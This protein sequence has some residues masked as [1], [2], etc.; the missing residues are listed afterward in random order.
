MHHSLGL[1]RLYSRYREWIL[2]YYIF[3]AGWTKIPLV[4]GLV[5]WV[6]NLYG[7]K[8][9][10][11]CLLTLDEA[12]EIIDSSAALALGPCTCRAVFKNCDHPLEAEIMVGLGHN[13]FIEE[14]PHDYRKINRQEAR[15]ILRDCHDRG[16][17]HTIVKCQQN[18][19][20]ICNCC[21]CCC[22]PLRLNKSYG[23]GKAL[24]RSAD[25]VQE[26]R[27]HQRLPAG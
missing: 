20:A 21:S 4:G 7:Q 2:R 17:I 8:A 6:A 24:T 3:Q 23:I 1:F 19:Y 5:R 9:S 10:S 15:S 27:K 25:I 22:V 13:V 18:F 11:A 12:E 14:R 26:F 16:L